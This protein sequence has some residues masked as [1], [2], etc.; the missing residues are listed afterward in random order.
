MHRLQEDQIRTNLLRIAPTL[1]ALEPKGQFANSV[2]QLQT[3]AGANSLL[4]WVNGMEFVSLAACLASALGCILAKDWLRQCQY[5]ESIS[6]PMVA[7][8]YRHLRLIALEK[9]HF[10]TIVPII[11]LLLHIATLTFLAGV[12]LSFSAYS[13]AAAI[14]LGSCFGAIYISFF[15]TRVMRCE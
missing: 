14:F 15:I 6:S 12:T 9:W 8:R 4:V 3:A 7:A 5:G 11:R 10:S 2:A 1:D 13:Q